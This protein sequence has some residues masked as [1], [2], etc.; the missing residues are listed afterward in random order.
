MKRFTITY[1]ILL[2]LLF[3]IFYWTV[4]PV[5]KFINYYQTKL[6]LWFLH[7]T[8]DAGRVDGVDVWIN[9]HYKIFIT[10]ACNGM[11]PI[12]VLTAAILAYPSRWTKKLLWIGIG[13]IVFTSMNLFRLYE[14][15]VFVKKQ[16][17]FHFYH[18]ILGNLILMVTG[19][20][21]FYFY[22]KSTTSQR[23]IR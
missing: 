18:D 19:L 8:L 6:A 9:S 5:A 2:P 14:V 3:A 7:T 10:N 1:L 11:I 13:Y 20:I 21:L 23:V 16:S 12:L 4:S 22:L 17:D 15:S